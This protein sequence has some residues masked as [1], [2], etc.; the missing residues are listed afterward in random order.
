M[1]LELQSME[2]PTFLQQAVLCCILPREDSQEHTI[3]NRTHGVYY[4]KH[5]KSSEAYA[6]T[7]IPWKKDYADVGD[8]DPAYTRRTGIDK[9][10]VFTFDAKEIAVDIAKG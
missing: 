8:Y 2:N 10:K 9:R 6:L 4:V 1:T 7:H 3:A 5:P